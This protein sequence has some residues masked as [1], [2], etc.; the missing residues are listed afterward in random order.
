MGTQRGFTLLE[1]I[2]AMMIS[3][4]LLALL[5][6]GL[7]NS[8]SQWQGIERITHHSNQQYLYLQHL[9]QQLQQAILV[10]AEDRTVLF[11]G[12][13]RELSFIAP[14]ELEQASGLY[15]YRLI[16]QTN[17]EQALL[18]LHIQPYVKDQDQTAELFAEILELYRG[19]APIRLTYA[20]TD[21]EG[22]LVW[23]E[24]WQQHQQLP[25]AVRLAM[26]TES[27]NMRH[28]PELMVRI[29]E[30]EYVR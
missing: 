3:G 27:P 23:Q 4:L 7:S 13:E 8:L 14:L 26:E 2:I 5:Y 9:R 11:E 18:Q 29:R 15:H 10:R 25:V 17:Q 6:S 20:D 16:Q 21:I 30:P 12:N 28:W 22:N 1:V 24:H 19:S